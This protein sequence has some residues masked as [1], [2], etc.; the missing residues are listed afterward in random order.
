MI[1][2]QWNRLS[3]EVILSSVVRWCS[4]KVEVSI[5]TQAVL[6]GGCLFLLCFPLGAI[7]RNAD[8]VCSPQWV[9]LVASLSLW[10]SA[11]SSCG[12]QIENNLCGQL[13]QEDCLSGFIL[14]DN[15]K[16]DWTCTQLVFIP[17][18]K[19]ALLLYWMFLWVWS[20]GGE[21]IQLSHSPLQS[22]NDQNSCANYSSAFEGTDKCCLWK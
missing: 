5:L 17:M 1:L 20:V 8:L 14:D 21:R 10:Y 18:L 11:D 16:I 6:C 3:C 7:H 22:S 13:C 4:G 2:N 19:W 15:K 12:R 9:E